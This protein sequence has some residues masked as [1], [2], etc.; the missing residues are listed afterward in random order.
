MFVAWTVVPI[1]LLAT[2]QSMVSQ[3]LFTGGNSVDRL[4]AVTFAGIALL[5]VRNW[6]A[7][8][9]AARAARTDARSAGEKDADASDED[10]L[11]RHV[12]QRVRVPDGHIHGLRAG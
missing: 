6:L 2:L 7:A 4:S 9:A 3:G 12:Q 1:A 5:L 11:R 8:L 10:A